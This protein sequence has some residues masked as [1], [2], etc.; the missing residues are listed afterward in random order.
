MHCTFSDWLRY[1]YSNPRQLEYA[2]T[3]FWE[4]RLSRRFR[5]RQ[6]ANTSEFSDSL[7]FWSTWAWFNSTK[8][9]Q[10]CA[11][12]QKRSLWKWQ[13][14]SVVGLWWISTARYFQENILAADKGLPH[15]IWPLSIDII[16]FLS[17]IPRDGARVKIKQLSSSPH[18]HQA[19]RLSTTSVNWRSRRMVQSTWL[20][21]H[22]IGHVSL[23]SS[24][25]AFKVP[26]SARQGSVPRITQESVSRTESF[27]H[28]GNKLGS[29]VRTTASIS[30]FGM[31]C[32][33][34][35]SVQFHN[36]F[37][38]LFSLLLLLTVREPPPQQADVRDSTAEVRCPKARL[39]RLLKKYHFVN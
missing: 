14:A 2:R 18:R 13:S 19:R 27:P 29:R 32:R 12:T 15:R 28:F 33:R 10:T 3:E 38:Q 1:K 39:V 9:R 31:R 37:K 11:S 5:R 24:A 25:D 7:C 21:L 20:L 17:A 30:S 22:G 4:I 35:Y 23:F 6:V 34:S 36:S 8:T 26:G 16:C